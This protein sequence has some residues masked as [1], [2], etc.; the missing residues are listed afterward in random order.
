[1][2]MNRDHTPAM[3]RLYQPQD[4]QACRVLW[5]ELTEWHRT[6]Y[7]SPDIGGSDP[8][9]RFDEH[10]KRVGPEHLWVA[11]VREQLVGLA[12]LILDA[13]EGE[14]EPLVVSE[15][16]RRQGIGRQLAQVVIAAARARGVDEVKVRPVARNELAIRFFH[17]LGFNILGHIELFMDFSS[18]DGQG[19]EP[20]E[21]LAGREF[22]R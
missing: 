11:E 17:E 10:L 9:R 22:H 12:G 3:I 6:I 19:W 4:L 5:V 15:P 21:Q 7:Q 20:G 18:P 2:K 16:Y 1:M 8:G 14:L 13:E